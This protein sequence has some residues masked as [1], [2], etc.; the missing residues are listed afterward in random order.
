VC[1]FVQEHNIDTVFSFLVHA[2]AVSAI[3]ARKLRGVRLI[4]SIQTIQRRPAWH[5]W[6]QSL[7]QSRAEKIVV[8]STAVARVARQRCHVPNERLV[9][10]PNAVDPADFTQSSVFQNDRPRVGFIGRLDPVKN[11]DQLILATWGIPAPHAELHI[12]GE[13]P[14]RPR[15]EAIIRRIDEPGCVHLHGVISRPQDALRQMDLLVLPSAEEGFGL[16][17]IEAMAAGVPVITAD[18]GG[19]LDIVQH[20]VNGLLAAPNA[21]AIRFQI[22]RVATDSTLRNRLIEAGLK[23]VREKFTW[24]IVLPQYRRLLEIDQS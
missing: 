10:I 24:D 20:E 6:L 15:L 9:V 23:T 21:Q 22:Q 13:G 2:N 8:P 5:W 12:F 11:V 7:I 4:Q 16:V 3:S 1:Q 14:E 17:L 18:S 19:V